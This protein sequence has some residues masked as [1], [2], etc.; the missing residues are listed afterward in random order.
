MTLPCSFF[1]IYGNNEQHSFQKLINMASTDDLILF[2]QVVEAGSFSKV[3]EQNS[4]TNSVVSK[5]I[6]RL[7]EELGVQLL[8]RT[9][10]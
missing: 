5:R 3:A 8:Y 6:G 1:A 4:L 7:E 9:T 10:R 2:A